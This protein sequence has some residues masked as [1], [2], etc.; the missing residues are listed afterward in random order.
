MKL[1]ALAISVLVL[2]AVTAPAAGADAARDGGPKVRVCGT[3]P[4]DGAYSYI[5]TVGI[6]CRPA[7]R[8]ANRA[9]RKYCNRHNNCNVPS[10]NTEREYRGPV[11]YHGWRC[12]VRVA[13]ELMRV[14]CSK[15]DM[16]IFRK[17]A[18]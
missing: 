5:R 12:N 8:V 9:R 3:L 17:T 10:T 1:A 16:R 11:A 15:R 14:R 18:S 2:C 13:W 6:R 7:Y 4:G